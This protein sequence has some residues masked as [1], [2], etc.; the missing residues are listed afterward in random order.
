MN[1]EIGTSAE[2][3]KTWNEMEEIRREEK[4]EQDGESVSWSYDPRGKA[5]MILRT[6][7]RKFYS[8]KNSA[9]RKW[10]ENEAKVD[11]AKRMVEYM[12]LYIYSS[13]YFDTERSFLATDHP[14]NHPR[15]I[16]M[17]MTR[18]TCHDFVM[19]CHDL[20][21][22][23]IVQLRLVNIGIVVSHESRSFPL[24]NYREIQDSATLRAV[25]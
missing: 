7:M 16:K 24:Y 21:N 11:R 1:G 15:W 4:R 25:N 14:L 13:I 18:S 23:I 22:N 10:Y 9:Q 5:S 6:G 2:K 3:R 12:Y 20:T 17:D 8:V 19:I